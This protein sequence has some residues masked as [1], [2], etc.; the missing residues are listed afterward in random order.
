M[1]IANF[2]VEAILFEVKSQTASVVSFALQFLLLLDLS[3][4]VHFQHSVKTLICKHLNLFCFGKLWYWV[5]HLTKLR[6]F[7]R[8][9]GKWFFKLC[10]QF[11]WPSQHLDCLFQL[12]FWILFVFYFIDKEIVKFKL[13]WLNSVNSQHVFHFNLIHR[14]VW[15]LDMF[16]IRVVSL[17][18]RC[19]IIINF[20]VAVQQTMDFTFE[21][22]RRFF[23]NNCYRSLDIQP[24]LLEGLCHLSNFLLFKLPSPHIEV[25]WSILHFECLRCCWLLCKLR[26]YVLVGLFFNLFICFYSIYHLMTVRHLFHN[27]RICNFFKNCLFL[28]FV[29]DS[30][31]QIKHNRICWFY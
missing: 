25:I 27:P 26:Q 10:R 8:W 16:E 9:V 15:L 14:E 17:W 28:L 12:C 6:S 30:L 1:V 3:V 20:V 29:A 2:V 22:L 4:V 18:V 11:V 19:I 31:L 21:S 23:I 7:Y 24:R 5:L 13:L